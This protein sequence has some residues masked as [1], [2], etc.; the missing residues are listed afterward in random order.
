M[1]NSFDVQ[2][3]NVL[4]EFPSWG[5]HRVVSAI[6]SSDP[7]GKLAEGVNAADWDTVW[8]DLSFTDFVGTTATGTA[9]VAVLF[10]SPAYSVVYENEEDNDD[11]S[12]VNEFVYTGGWVAQDVISDIALDSGDA[13]HKTILLSVYRRPFFLKVSALGT[14]AVLHMLVSGCKRAD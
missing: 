10:W 7:S 3:D 9:T 8:V 13:K 11:E 2:G 12:E 4:P 6:D 14:N 5:V 1:S